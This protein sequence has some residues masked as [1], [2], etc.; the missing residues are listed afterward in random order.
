MPESNETDMDVRENIP[1]LAT[2]D[3]CL[4]TCLQNSGGE[5]KNLE[6]ADQSTL[7]SEIMDEVLKTH[8]SFS[9]L[10]TIHFFYLLLLVS[11]LMDIQ[12]LQQLMFTITAEHWCKSPEFEE[13]KLSSEIVKWLTIP[14]VFKDGT[15]MYDKCHSYDVNFT[16]LISENGT[17]WRPSESWP[18]KKC[19]NGWNYDFR[20]NLF[21][22]MTTEY[23]WVCDN[24]WKES[25]VLSSFWFGSVFGPLTFGY[26]SDRYG[27]RPV[28]VVSFFYAGV[29]SI[30][31]CFMP[32]FKSISIMRCLTGFAYWA[33]A[34]I[35]FCW[36]KFIPESISWVVVNKNKDEGMK[37]IKKVAKINRFKLGDEQEH[38]FQRK[39]VTFGF[40]GLTHAAVS[41][42]KDPIM[43]FSIGSCFEISIPFLQIL[44]MDSIGRRW[45]NFGFFSIS[46]IMAFTASL[47]S[48][49]MYNILW[50]TEWQQS[51]YTVNAV[52]AFMITTTMAR[53]FITGA[54]QTVSPFA[55]E[56]FPTKIRAVS[57]AVKLTANA[58]AA[59]F[60]PLTIYLKHYHKVL[61]L[62]VLGTT[63]II[64]AVL[65]TFLPETANK[66]L[67]HT[68]KE[69]DEFGE[70]QKYFY[71]PCCQN[72]RKKEKQR[73]NIG[74]E[75]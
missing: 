71:M 20:S 43:A 47:L 10:E 1:E 48:A 15:I 57:I 40:A 12:V 66:T 21:Q 14:E 3:A 38:W 24:A 56:L 26:L 63:A 16:K 55:V 23:D 60:A 68:L 44:F 29:T 11:P 5:P 9:V 37:I 13:L 18:K 52:L 50:Y 65:I 53:V 59:L 17:D 4:A 46:A 67:P 75:L 64:G 45:T 27:R 74:T 33:L 41:I 39:L 7:P 70:H 36:S 61:P 54:F 49:G 32:D 58:L 19:E 2:P 6:D 25:F 35:P 31:T 8:G 28:T 72:F 69:G 73:E 42:T 34:T 51:H 30:L 22:S 62:Q